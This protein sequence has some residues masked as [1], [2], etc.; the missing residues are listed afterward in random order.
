MSKNNPELLTP[1]QLRFIAAWHGSATQA[2]K[3]AGYKYPNVAAAKLMKNPAVTAAVRLRQR[4][5]IEESVKEWADELHF[6]GADLL[7]RLWQIAQLDSAQ[8][9]GSFNPQ[10]RACFI[11]L[12]MFSSDLPLLP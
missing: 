1:Q 12:Q 2:A 7:N 6:V 5:I 9:H 11:L 8:T 10:L 3:A 4:E